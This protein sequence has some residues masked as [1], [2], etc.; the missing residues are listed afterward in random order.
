M[1]AKD[2]FAVGDS[3]GV[4]GGGRFPSMCNLGEGDKRSPPLFSPRVFYKCSL[5]V[6][7]TKTY[8]TSMWRKKQGFWQDIEYD[9]IPQY[10]QYCNRLGHNFSNCK[11]NVPD[12]SNFDAIHEKQVY[13]RKDHSA[14][15]AGKD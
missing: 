8:K 11:F 6:G 14:N 12:N 3:R 7:S 1:L 10:C 5:G 9:R 13:R 15:V 2:F 4:D